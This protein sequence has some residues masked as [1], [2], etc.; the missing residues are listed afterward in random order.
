M[1]QWEGWEGGAAPSSSKVAVGAGSEF[2]SLAVETRPSTLCAQ[3]LGVLGFPLA[4]WPAVGPLEV[5][6]SLPWLFKLLVA[7]GEGSK[8]RSA[9]KPQQRKAPA[10]RRQRS[11]VAMAHLP[12]TEEKARTPAYRVPLQA[13]DSSA[14]P[15]DP[16]ECLSLPA[17]FSLNQTAARTARVRLC[18]ICQERDTHSADEFNRFV[19][20]R[21][22]R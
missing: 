6:G 21:L 5:L 22:K 10:A 3:R 19:H 11:T 20:K 17:H 15:S 4:I 1:W 9:S 14:G 12:A 8:R 18:V 13:I 7:F 16:Y 2:P